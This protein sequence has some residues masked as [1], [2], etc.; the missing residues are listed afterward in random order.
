MEI[1]LHKNG[2][3]LSFMGAY[4]QAGDG[5]TIYHEW[6]NQVDVA[7]EDM[8]MKSFYLLGAYFSA[9][10]FQKYNST[11]WLYRAFYPFGDDGL[12][13][14]ASLFYSGGVNM[15]FGDPFRTTFTAVGTENLSYSNYLN[16]DIGV[17]YNF[18]VGILVKGNT[19][20]VVMT[21]KHAYTTPAATQSIVYNGQLNFFISEIET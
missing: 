15:P 17:M 4:T 12:V 18:P 5:T 3:V 6:L 16:F 19:F 21:F 20:T 2:R 1:N 10:C 9:E 11:D 14:N 13:V 8:P 7:F